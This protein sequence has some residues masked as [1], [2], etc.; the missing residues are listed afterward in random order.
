M[1]PLTTPPLADVIK[2]DTTSVET[3]ITSLM[4]FYDPAGG[5][6]WFN[7]LRA[8]KAVRTAYH[9]VHRLDLLEATTP[10]EKKRVGYKANQDVISLASPLAFGRTTQ[11][12]YLSGRRFPFGRERYASY[13]IPFFFIEGKI[14][15]LYFLQYRK[16]Y[17]L[18][19][20]DYAGLYTVH[21]RFLLDQEFYDLQVDVEY[22]DCGAIEKDGPRS[23][24]SHNSASFE[25]WSVV[26]LDDHLA[27]VSLARD[28]IERRQLKVKR[29]RP[30]KD[31]T[32]PLFD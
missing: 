28:E 13:R 19:A 6:G 30:L 2:A 32:L 11:T 23:L 26:R 27:L 10:S 4:E 16:N 14:V 5:G 1:I 7:Y 9:G 22:V 15:K 25:M 21:K 8:I 24:R 18:T 31:I 3:A 29:I 12:F 17:F 20:D